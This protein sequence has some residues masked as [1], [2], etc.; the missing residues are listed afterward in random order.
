M[1]ETPERDHELGE[2]LR[3]LPVPEH[4]PGFELRLRARLEQPRPARLGWL[5]GRGGRLALAGGL[6]ALLVVA[7]TLAVGLPGQ[8][9][10]ATAA[11]IRATVTKAL[12]SV[13]T[14]QGVFVNREGGGESRW[15]FVVD[16][17][18]NFRITSLAGAGDLAYDTLTNV[19]SY[20]DG[21]SFVERVGIAPG[22]PDAD[23]S[24]WVVDRGLGSVVGTLATAGNADV[25]EVEY[26]GRPAWLL[27]T[28][29]GN[30][31]EER[32][33]TVDRETGVPV[34]SVRSR[35]DRVLD[36]WRVEGLRVGESAPANRFRLRRSAGQDAAVRYDMGFRRVRLGEVAGVAGYEPLVPTALPRGF[37][38]AAVA[39]A[40]RSRPTGSEQRQNPESRNV[41]SLS[42]RRG[43]DRITVTTREIG[44]D[45][46]AWI[47]PV[48]VGILA[49]RPEQV[50]F[51]GGALD[52]ITGELVVDPGA[53][54]HV[55]ALT[56]DLVV[57]V[58][59]DLSRDELLQV[60]ESLS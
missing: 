26:E 24:P 27:R 3:A 1:I 54:P 32:A 44:S 18:G 39:V 22:P 35:G 33:I 16:E 14:L 34:R 52:G 17:Q 12:S 2:A 19:E 10:V 57:T 53:T 43:L 15:R 46:S 11:E 28:P 29:T 36:E 37:E 23:A 40:L 38:L 13:G 49:G 45:R 60:A 48:T 58:T 7:A 41:V 4:L 47:D 6:A 55:W 25:E 21:P 30:P 56:D 20:S 50:T 59:G 9:D 8:S 51:T 5:R 42:F 31:G